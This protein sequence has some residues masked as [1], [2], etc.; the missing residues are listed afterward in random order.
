MKDVK[1]RYEKVQ[2]NDFQVFT[3]CH[4]CD[5]IRSPLSRRVYEVCPCCG[6]SN[7]DVLTLRSI[8]YHPRLTFWQDLKNFWAKEHVPCVVFRFET[9]ADRP[10]MSFEGVYPFAGSPD[11]VMESV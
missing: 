2:A 4:R 11:N 10:F 6:N 9:P 5:W 7:L 8:A 1:I 3:V